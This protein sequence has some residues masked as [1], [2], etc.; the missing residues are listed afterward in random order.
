MN[1]K[2]NTTDSVEQN[3]NQNVPKTG[4]A[5]RLFQWLKRHRKKIAIVWIVISLPFCIYLAYTMLSQR[6]LFSS[7]LKDM[8]TKYSYT[9]DSIQTTSNE[10]VSKVFTWAVRSE[11]IRGNVEQTDV[12]FST[13]VREKNISKISLTNSGVNEIILSSDKND[14]NT[15]I[16]NNDFVLK[17]D[18]P[19][20]ISDSTSNRVFTPVLGI[21]KKIGILEL[22]FQK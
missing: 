13:L 15:S 2:E 18:E 22:V 4:V 10:Q 7:T 21:D 16:S 1:I 17:N 20:T 12:L 3:D 19:K 11:M 9:I 6:A 8:E 5:K 14:Q